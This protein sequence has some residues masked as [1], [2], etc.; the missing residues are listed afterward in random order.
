LPAHQPLRGERLEALLRRLPD[1]PGVYLMKDRN[2]RV[3]YVG[4]AKSLRSRVRSY[5]RASGDQRAFISRLDRVLFDIQVRVT[6]SEKDAL[7]MERE[8]IRHHRPRYNIDLLDD[9]MFLSIRIT[10]GHDFPRLMLDRRRPGVEVDRKKTGRWFGPYTSAKSVRETYRLIQSVFQLRT[11]PDTVFKTRKR[12][13]LQHQMGRCLGP[14]ALT[15]SGDEYARKVDQA[16]LVLKGHYD[17]LI[18]RLQGQM[19][20]ASAGLRFEEAAR[21]RDR[22]RA[23]ERTLQQ[24]RVIDGGQLDRDVV[25][26][27]REGASGVVLLMQVR[28][29]R[30]LGDG[31][32]RFSGIEAPNA[33]VVRQFL[34]QHYAAGADLPGE[35]LLPAEAAQGAEGRGDLQVLTDWLSELRRAS[36]RVSIPQRGKRTHLVKTARENAAAAYR[37]ALATASILGDRLLRLQARLNLSRLPRRIECFDISTLSGQLSVGSMAVLQDGEPATS[38]YRRYRIREAAP[39]SDV[40]MLREVV[41]RRLRRVVEGEEE[42]PDLILLDGG[43][44]QLG[45]VAAL[46]AD[47]GVSDVD[48]AALAKG[49]ATK[50]HER[51]FVPG[52][53]NPVLLLPDSDELFLLSRV[54]DE[55][56][57]FAVS[58][59][60]KLRRKRATRSVLDEIPG[61]GPVLR[62]SLLV[63]FGSLK[64]VREASPQELAG[65]KGVT[66]ALAK[67]ISDFLASIS[68]LTGSGGADS[69]SGRREK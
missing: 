48:L 16:V 12:P 20:C 40:D 27:F 30:W 51:V 22:I 56:H 65:V 24:Q 67:R 36:V 66:P 9:K 60:R 62:K 46:F 31:R 10:A 3:I 28:Q 11:C 13:C 4:K 32:F 2:D 47:L 57:R 52:R 38:Q 63:H 68:S 17:E 34:S 64:G 59:H 7:I 29:G 58:Y 19:K 8:L 5:F 23:L 25:G 1:R 55:A 42:A 14:C 44:G 35:L 50:R 39:D 43:R 33:D 54:R 26:F 18:E 41:S 69:D 6:S 49:R 45:V 61:I 21:I 15:V 37:T 53:K